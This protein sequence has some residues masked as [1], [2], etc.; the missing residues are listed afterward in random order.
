[1]SYLTKLTRTRGFTL[2]EL[3][4]VIAIIGILS[5]VVL[6]SL[7]GARADA[8]DSRRQQDLAQ[9]RTAIELCAN[10]NQDYS[11]C[12]GSSLTSGDYMQTLPQDPSGNSYTIN[13]SADGYC[14]YT[15]DWEDTDNIPDNDTGCGGDYSLGPGT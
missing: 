10:D 8:R 5:S 6:A 3:L 14:I 12:D 9:I 7:N 1:M 13:V 11:S 15:S 4:V 2:I